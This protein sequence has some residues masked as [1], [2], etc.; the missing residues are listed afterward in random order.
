[1]THF[2]PFIE[3]RVIHR[4]TYLYIFEAVIKYTYLKPW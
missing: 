4:Q 1:M 2:L 3:R